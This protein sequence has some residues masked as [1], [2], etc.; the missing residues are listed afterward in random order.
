MLTRLPV[1]S[2]LVSDVG[3]QQIPPIPRPLAA[4]HARLGA[5]MAEFGG[6]LMPLSYAGAVE[7]HLATRSAVGIFDVSHLG[8]AIVRGEGATEFVNACFTNDLDRIGDGQAQYT[9]CCDEE[10][11][12][13]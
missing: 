5:R 2:R 1:A 12:G 4:E 10:T 9:L 7:E 13:V 3:A 11:G 6:W 8:K